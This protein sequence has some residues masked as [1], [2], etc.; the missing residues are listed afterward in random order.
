MALQPK[1]KDSWQIKFKDIDIHRRWKDQG[2][3]QILELKREGGIYTAQDS[4]EDTGGWRGG[5][6]EELW[7]R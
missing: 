4:Q 2:Y 6:K 3:K 7:E 1:I 5:T